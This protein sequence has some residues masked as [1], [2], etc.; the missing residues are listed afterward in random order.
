MI[1]L[2][3][4]TSYSVKIEHFFFD[5]LYSSMEEGMDA[6]LLICYAL[7][8]SDKTKLIS[9]DTEAKQNT[10]NESQ[11]HCYSK[12]FY[13]SYSDFVKAC[14]DNNVERWT[15]NI[16][17][18]DDNI[19]FMGSRGKGDFG[20]TYFKS[21]RIDIFPL[22]RDVENNAIALKANQTITE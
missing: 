11:L 1:N 18:N 13:S 5:R 10:E 6:G 17:Y 20:V 7:L 3:K 19:T 16:S 22:L 2:F 4:Y 8:T 12:S 14:D 9:L 15:L 21:K